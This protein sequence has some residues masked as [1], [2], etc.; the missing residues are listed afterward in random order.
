MD[1]LEL[2]E[3]KKINRYLG[4]NKKIILENNFY[5]VT[6]RAPGKEQLFLEENDYLYFLYLLKNTSNDF[7]LEI[8]SFVLMPN[9]L[10]LLLYLTQRNLD[11]A[12]KKLFQRYATYFNRKY[13]RKGHVF[14]GVY[15]CALCREEIYLLAISLYIH[16]NPLKARLCKDLCDYKW[17]SIQLYLDPS[18]TSFVKNDFILNILHCDR[19]KAIAEY[20]RLLE[21]CARIKYTPLLENLRGLEKIFK[22]VSVQAS[23]F[24]I[25]KKEKANKKD[26]LE[27]KIRQFKDKRRIVKPEEKQA[28]IYVIEQLKSRGFRVKEISG[29]LGISRHKIYR[30]CNISV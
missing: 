26:F 21:E 17:S 16:L 8:Y 23:S 27:E 4:V 24:L 22:K 13:Q 15:R 7:G 30:L 18:K 10:H 29:I 28:L 11:K 14:C 25:K 9:H 1:I 12:M 20:K 3:K 2:I 19:K 5:H 6:Q